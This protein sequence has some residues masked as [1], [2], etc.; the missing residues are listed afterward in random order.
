VFKTAAS[1]SRRD[2]EI[3]DKPRVAEL[4]RTQHDEIPVTRFR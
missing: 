1:T 4:C 3:I 2:F